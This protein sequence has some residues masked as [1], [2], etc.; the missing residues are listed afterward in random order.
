MMKWTWIALLALVSLGCKTQYYGQCEPP[1]DELEILF[2]A[3]SS[4]NPFSHNFCVVCNTEISPD[5]YEE[6]ALD[7][8]APQGPTFVDNVHP[9]LY[10][11]PDSQEPEDAID[12]LEMCESI[13]CGG[14]AVYN[15]M[16]GKDQGNFD[17]TPLLDGTSAVAQEWVLEPTMLEPVHTTPAPMIQSQQEAPGLQ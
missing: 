6:W 12:S 7:M 8:G 10:V 14:Q 17:V 16:V 1:Q 3:K 11:Y 5:Q 15:D 2:K 13:V 9:C 4:A